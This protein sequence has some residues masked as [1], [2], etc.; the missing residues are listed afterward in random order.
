MKAFVY[1]GLMLLSSTC[2][3]SCSQFQ[4]QKHE[5]A[6]QESTQ[7]EPPLYLG[8]VHQVFQGDKFA[9]LRIIG[10][11]P[12]EGTVLITH[13]ADGYTARMGNLIVSA[14]GSGGKNI[15][16]AD[17]RAGVIMKGDLVFKYRSISAEEEEETTEERP[18]PGTLTETNLD[19]DYMPQDVAEKLQRV[20][21]EAEEAP[22]ATLQ[23]EPAMSE[24][25]V[26][27]APQY[28]PAEPSIPMPTERGRLDDI[29]DT[30]GGW[31]AI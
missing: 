30:I 13:P 27:G 6:G 8:S 22:A 18:D 15:I 5:P 29:P 11:I 21:M 2:L 25:T 20:R 12:G 17:I 19:T 7:E 28:T 3:I 4:Q 24:A 26:E 31:D 9:L 14:A 1:A 16:A 23:P 10:P